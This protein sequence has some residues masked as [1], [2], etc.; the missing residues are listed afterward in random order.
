V[1]RTLRIVNYA[2]NGSGTGHLTRLVA[3]SRWLRRYSAWAGVRAEIYFLTSSEADGLPLSEQFAAFKLPS[4]TIVQRAGIDKTTYLALAKQ[5]VWHSLGILRPDLFVVDTFPRGSF[6]ELV[7][8]LDLAKQRALVLRPMQAEFARRPDVQA[9]LPLYDLVLV[10]EHES[11]AQMTLPEAARAH[12]RYVGP[13]AVRDRAE[14]ATR[15][16]ARQRL[17]LDQDRPVVYV[18]AGGG[19]DAEAERHITRVIGALLCSNTELSIVVGAGPLYRGQ[20]PRNPRVTWLVNESAA[21]LAAGFDIAV[22]AAGYNTFVELMLAGVPTVFVPQRKIADDQ[23]ARAERAVAAGA[24]SLLEPGASDQSL[25]DAVAQLL[26]PQ[27]HR[28]ASL[29]AR[30]LV[31]RSCARTAA[32]ELLRLQ[33]SASEVDRA[34]VAVGDALLQATRDLNVSCETLIELMHLLDADG[35]HGSPQSE[36]LDLQRRATALLRRAV[37]AG[38]DPAA[39]NELSRALLRRSTLRDA[40]AREALICEGMQRFTAPDGDQPE[41]LPQ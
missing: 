11:D 17:G 19:G 29:A 39:L 4:K 13:I 37:D 32:A 10:P 41:E 12:T 23:A 22:T 21:E 28:R 31:P 14:L 1:K 7:N 16:D 8:A 3:I 5:W 36:L 24:A 18:S 35:G 20:V 30:A 15:A 40:A 34:E 2:V 26:D 9:M 25:I 38:I 33:L 27:V 6:G